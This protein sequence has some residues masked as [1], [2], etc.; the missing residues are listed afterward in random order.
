MTILTPSYKYILSNFKDQS[1]GQ[2][3]QF[4]ENRQ[5]ERGEFEMVN[6]G[7]TNEEVAAILIDRLQGLHAKLPSKQSAYAIT[8]FQDGL[9]W[10]N[11]RT[12]ER[13]ARGVEGTPKA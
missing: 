6:D 4:I 5:N 13:K 8:K 7:T 1:A 12:D 11:N 3:I 10:L 2:T 9:F